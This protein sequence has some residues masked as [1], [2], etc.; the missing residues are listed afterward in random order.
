MDFAGGEAMRGVLSERRIP[1]FQDFKPAAQILRRLATGEV[2]PVPAAAAHEEHAWLGGTAALEL[3]AAQGISI[4][5][6]GRAETPEDARAIAQEIGGTVVVKVDHP[7]VLHKTEVGGVRVGVAPADVAGVCAQMREAIERL[8]IGFAPTGGFLVQEQVTDATEV[9][10]GLV[11]DPTFGPVLSLGPGGTLVEFFDQ[12]AFRGMPFS[13]ED[14][15][16]ALGE[17]PLGRLLAEHRQGPRDT[18]ALVALVL[19]FQE[20]VIGDDP[21]LEGDLNPV[22]VRADG[23]GCVVVDARLRRPA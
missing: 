15:H 14:V 3:L 6:A 22:L 13:A 10:V 18:A 1:S 23:Q 16:D 11:S 9:L 21:L 17:T 19:A 8:G 7:E 2:R 4:P 5:R 20:L 12:V